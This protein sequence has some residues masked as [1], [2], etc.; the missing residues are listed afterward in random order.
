MASETR[1][2]GLMLSRIAE[3][4]CLDACPASRT[5]VAVENRG[6]GGQVSRSDLVMCLSAA[7]PLPDSV[8]YLSHAMSI[9]ETFVKALKVSHSGPGPGQRIGFPPGSAQ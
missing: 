1:F 6:G 5:D 4:N 9:A 2:S 7:Y 8:S 3:T